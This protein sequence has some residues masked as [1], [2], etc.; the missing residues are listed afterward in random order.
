[1]YKE[2]GE[3][4]GNEAQSSLRSRWEGEKVYINRVWEGPKANIDIL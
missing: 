4:E 3:G 2:G 1:M